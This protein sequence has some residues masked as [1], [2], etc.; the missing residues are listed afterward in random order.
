M[1]QLFNNHY[2]NNFDLGGEVTVDERVFWFWAHDQQGGGHE[3]NRKPRGFG[4]EY[5][6]LSAVGVQVTT[7]F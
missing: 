1:V 4:S 3:V 5:K 7:T 2:K 6:C